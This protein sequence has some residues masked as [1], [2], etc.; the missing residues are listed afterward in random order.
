MLRSLSIYGLLE[1]KLRYLSGTKGRHDPHALLDTL[2]GP[3]VR[4]RAHPRAI[5]VGGEGC[6]SVRG[7][8]TERGEYETVLKGRARLREPRGWIRSLSS[9][10]CY[11]ESK[12]QI[13]L[14]LQ[15]GAVQYSC[16]V[17]VMI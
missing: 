14:R 7:R 13:K 5:R 9:V 15:G 4:G 3:R 16:C 11:Y 8:D 6:A 12:D 17:E 1:E 2:E 10:C